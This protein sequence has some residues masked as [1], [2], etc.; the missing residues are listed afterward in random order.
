LA[1]SHSVG[2]KLP[3]HTDWNI[4]PGHAGPAYFRFERKLKPSLAYAP[5]RAA[6][7]LPILAC[8]HA[9]HGPVIARNFYNTKERA[10]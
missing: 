9:Q 10:I 6:Q 7:S 1:A 2:Q 4:H 3:A 5:A 8:G